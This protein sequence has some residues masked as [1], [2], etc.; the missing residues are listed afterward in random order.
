MEQAKLKGAKQL[1][2]LGFL[3]FVGCALYALPGTIISVIGILKFKK[4][5]AEAHTDL[6]KYESSWVDAR[7]GLILCVMG[8]ITSIVTLIWTI[9]LFTK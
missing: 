3:S 8:L 5:K 1:I 6:V 2:L 9:W 4:I 7:V